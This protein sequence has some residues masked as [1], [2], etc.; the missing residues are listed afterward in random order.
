MAFTRFRDRNEAG[1]R[2]ATLLSAYENRPDA[3]VLALPRGGVPVGYEVAAALG[4]ARCASLSRCS[5]PEVRGK[6][7][8]V[9]GH[10]SHSPRQQCLLH[11]P[12]QPSSF[13]GERTEEERYSDAPYT[14]ESL[15]PLL[16][17]APM[18]RAL[19]RGIE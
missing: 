2:L 4:G 14:P 3:V 12:F 7:W 10:P 5:A 9:R 17:S 6:R 16:A 18:P 1:Q 19:T 8:L 15:D 11:P 13:R